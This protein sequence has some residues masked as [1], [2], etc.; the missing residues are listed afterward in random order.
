[1]ARHV[2]CNAEQGC[3]A[4]WKLRG[5]SASA[6]YLYQAGDHPV[7]LIKRSAIPQPGSY[8]HFHWTGSESLPNE[9]E[10][11]ERPG[12]LLELQ[13]IDTFCFV[14]HGATSDQSGTCANFGGLKVVP[15]LDVSTHTNIVTSVEAPSNH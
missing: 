1:M 12:F 13:A 3:T 11:V 6:Q 15:G 5:R 8:T 7:W 9:P 4:G 14:H 2:D 10:D